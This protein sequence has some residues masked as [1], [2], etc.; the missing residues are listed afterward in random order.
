MF[1]VFKQILKIYNIENSNSV[2]FYIVK[3]KYIEVNRD[4]TFYII[5]LVKDA[6]ARFVTDYK[7][8]KI[9]T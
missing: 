9:Q 7:G 8:I 3:L 6:I 5:V 2:V 4:P 1:I